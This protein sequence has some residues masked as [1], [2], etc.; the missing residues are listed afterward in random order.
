[1]LQKKSQPSYFFCPA[2]NFEPEL[3]T[4]DVSFSPP[5]MPCRAQSSGE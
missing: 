2:K 5:Q 1:M 3:K 4:I